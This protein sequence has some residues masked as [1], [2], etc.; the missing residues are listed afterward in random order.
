MSVHLLTNP[1]QAG[2]CI[3][4]LRQGDVLVWLTPYDGAPL[5][6]SVGDAEVLYLA[7]PGTWDKTEAPPSAR[8]ITSPELAELI[9]RRGPAI[10]WGG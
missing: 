5:L 10:T 8:A 3:A 1:G 9:A 7:T 2:A 6:L 4:N